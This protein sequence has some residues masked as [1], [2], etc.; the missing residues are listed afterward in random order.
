MSNSVIKCENVLISEYI[1]K[2]RSLQMECKKGK[3]NLFLLK[4]DI[5]E[6]FNTFNGVVKNIDPNLLLNDFFDENLN[7]F[8]IDNNS[9]LNG[10]YNIKTDKNFVIQSINF[11]NHIF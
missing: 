8:K 11:I 7:F 9:Q 4:A 2:T 5:A 3:N 10:S 6:N 1:R